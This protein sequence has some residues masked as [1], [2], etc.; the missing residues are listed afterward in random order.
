MVGERSQML[1]LRI[2]KIGELAVVQ[3]SGK[4]VRNGSA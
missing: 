2:E 3:C 4:I 1:E